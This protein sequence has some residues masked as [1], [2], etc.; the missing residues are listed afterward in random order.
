VRNP[1]ANSAIFLSFSTALTL[2][3]QEFHTATLAVPSVGIGFE[4]LI[5][6]TRYKMSSILFAGALLGA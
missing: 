6:V 4:D 1:I 2:T 3:H 5:A